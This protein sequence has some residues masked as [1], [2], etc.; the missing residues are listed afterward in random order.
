[1][2]LKMIIVPMDV[3]SFELFA[4][5]FLTVIC[6]Y[7]FLNVLRR[8]PWASVANARSVTFAG[9]LL[10]SCIYYWLKLLNPLIS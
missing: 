10:A 6:V 2:H 8:R 4:L 7:R 9:G 3:H 5:L 1:M